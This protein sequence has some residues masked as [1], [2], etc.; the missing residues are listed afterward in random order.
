MKIRQELLHLTTRRR[1]PAIIIDEVDEVNLGVLVRKTQLGKRLSLT[2]GLWVRLPVVPFEIEARR[3]GP[4]HGDSHPAP[5]GPDTRFHPGPG[6]L[7]R[8]KVPC[9]LP[10][11]RVLLFLLRFFTITLMFSIRVHADQLSETLRP[12]KGPR[13]FDVPGILLKQGLGALIPLIT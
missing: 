12:V 6:P 1:G 4:S 3:P 11:D 7:R 2:L 13:P 5:P 8:G 10:R 9:Q